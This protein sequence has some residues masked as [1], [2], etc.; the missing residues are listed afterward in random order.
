MIFLHKLIAHRG[1]VNNSKDNSL[2]SLLNAI[3]SDK[4]IG[5]ETDVRVTKDNVFVLYHDALYKGNLVKNVLYKE[6][7]KDNIMRLDDLLKINTN[8]IIL[9]E[10]KDYYMNI[11]LFLR[12]LDKFKSNIYIMSFNNKIIKKI[13]DKTKKYKVGIL[14]YVF[15]NI[16]DYKFDFICILNDFLNEDIINK[17][18]NIEVF[19]YGIRNW[20]NIK[21]KGVF[22]IVDNKILPNNF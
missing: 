3:N 9:L 22:Y 13:R 14:N 18:K 4:Y 11:E 16:N 1:L 10:I 17:Y 6:M 19:S 20:K 12:I 21:F 5:V 7:K 2:E 8:K 15:N